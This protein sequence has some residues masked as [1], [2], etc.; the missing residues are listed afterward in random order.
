MLYCALK[1]DRLRV[2]TVQARRT[3]VPYEFDDD[4]LLL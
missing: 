2:G 4:D 1:K 3:G